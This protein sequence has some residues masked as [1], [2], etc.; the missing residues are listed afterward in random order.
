MM[1]HGV[2]VTR[3]RAAVREDPRNP[4]NTFHDWDAP[5]AVDIPSCAIAPRLTPEAATAGRTSVVDGFTVYM[6][7]DVDIRATDRI[8]FADGIVRK[9]DG[10]P[11]RWHNPFTGLDAG[12]EVNVEGVTG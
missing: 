11:A 1:P 2:I 4:E 6:P 10:E 12:V 8:R 5:D 7:A 9:I 3:L